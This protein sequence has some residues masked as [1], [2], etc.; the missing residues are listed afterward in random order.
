[1]KWGRQYTRSRDSARFKSTRIGNV[2]KT[3]Q[4][5]VK[6]AMGPFMNAPGAVAAATRRS[7]RDLEAALSVMSLS[8]TNGQTDSMKSGVSSKAQGSGSHVGTDRVVSTLSRADT[9]IMNARRKQSIL[10]DLVIKLQAVCRMYFPRLRF[11]KFRRSIVVLQMKQKKL[12]LTPRVEENT[13][14]FKLQVRRA[15]TIQCC[16]RRFLALSEARRRHKAIQMIQKHLRGYL[17]FQRFKRVKNSVM[18]IQKII[19][20]RK[21]RFVFHLVL[22]LLSHVQ[23]RVRGILVRKQ[24]ELLYQQRMT[25]YREQIFLLWHMANVPLSL[26]T[27]LWP[28]ISSG[29]GSSRLRLAESELNR[30]WES[31][32]MTL[33]ANIQNCN[34]ETTRL[35]DLL[36]LDNGTY[37]KCL[38]SAKLVRGNQ[39]SGAS[40]PQIQKAWEAVEAERLQ[41]YERLDSSRLLTD[42]EGIYNDFDIPRNEKMKKVSLAKSICEYKYGANTTRFPFFSLIFFFITGVNRDQLQVRREVYIND[43]ADF[44]GTRE[45]L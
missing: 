32:G 16:V 39:V 29:K 28:T 1:M 23:A 22:D 37:C 19:K 12:I 42:I 18:F 38:T 6:K 20:A 9:I 43:D 25:L 24:F 14:F 8:T 26:R 5:I 13:N 7:V 4:E 45:L 15:T 10:L 11:I 40:S 31:L 36:G 33:D 41:V 21:A 17:A 2:R 34:N 30:V 44:S 3:Q 35:A 27:K